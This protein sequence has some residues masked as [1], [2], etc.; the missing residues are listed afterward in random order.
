M[1]LKLCCDM[2]ED[3][4]FTQIFPFKEGLCWP[5]DYYQTN[6]ATCHH[7]WPGPKTAHGWVQ[8]TDFEPSGGHH[9]WAS[10]WRKLLWMGGPYHWSGGNLLG[11]WRLRGQTLFSSRLSPLSSQN[12]IPHR[13]LPSQHLSRWPSMHFNTTCPW[14]G[15]NGIWNISW[16]MVARPVCWKDFVVSGIHVGRTKWWVS[17]QCWCFQNVEGW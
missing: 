10:Q 14:W 4:K 2:I 7:G 1:Q 3:L 9:R 6:R 8:A 15:S 12:E 5:R 17:S 16:K 11:R 13:P